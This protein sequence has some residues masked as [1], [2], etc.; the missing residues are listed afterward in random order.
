MG[1]WSYW[2]TTSVSSQIQPS[3]LKVCWYRLFT[4]QPTTRKMAIAVNPRHLQPDADL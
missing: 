1:L 3:T 2:G 4:E